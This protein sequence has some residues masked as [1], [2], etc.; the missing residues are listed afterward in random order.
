MRAT[1][2]GTEGF[3][4][5]WAR[6]KEISNRRTRSLQG[7]FLYRQG[8]INELRSLP[9]FHGAIFGFSTVIPV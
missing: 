7:D 8:G 5:S 4:E 1:G 3:P 9:H 6:W 2:R